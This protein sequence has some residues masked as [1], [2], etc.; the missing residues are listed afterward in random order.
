MKRILS[1]LFAIS[2]ASLSAQMKPEQV[3]QKQLEH[4]NGRDIDGFMSVIDPKITIHEFS[5]GKVLINGFDDCKK[6]YSDLFAKSPK[7]HSKLITRTVMSNKVIDHEYITG[8]N[9]SDTATELVLIYEVQ[10]DKI[11]KITV[12]RK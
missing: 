11:H 8:R 10:D 6:F 3:V 5:D 9:G 12:I 2:L 1:F 4:Y 7:L